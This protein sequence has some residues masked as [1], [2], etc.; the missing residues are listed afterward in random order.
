[1]NTDLYGKM[2]RLQWL[3]H[4]HHMR[5]AFQGD[6]LADATR[7]QGRILA[8][9]QLKDGISTKDLSYLLGLAVSS[10]N[11]FLAK[12]ERG[13]YI[14]REASPQD[15]RVML[16]Y[17]TD[18]GRKQH[19]TETFDPDDIFACLTSDEQE[20]LGRYLDKIIDAIEIDEDDDFGGNEWTRTA[21]A[22]RERMSGEMLAQFG[23]DNRI[24]NRSMRRDF[25]EELRREFNK[26]RGR[27]GRE[28]DNTKG[29][30]R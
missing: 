13:G 25:R 2:M 30:N 10:L 3:L 9:L 23:R 8:A 24:D 29:N 19:Q 28:D 22:V 27:D 1:M 11:E 7:G 5:R 21:R 16:V 18:K 12:L 15:R 6:H 14:R 4:R 26:A 20:N 17:L